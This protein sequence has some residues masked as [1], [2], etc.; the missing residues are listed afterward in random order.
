MPGRFERDALH[1]SP[2][3]GVPRRGEESVFNSPIVA[4]SAGLVAGYMSPHANSKSRG[5]IVQEINRFCREEDRRLGFQSH[6]Q[7]LRHQAGIRPASPDQELRWRRYT[8]LAETLGPQLRPYAY[9]FRTGLSFEEA[10]A[11]M[12]TR[13][14]SA[15][16]VDHVNQSLA[17]AYPQA[18]G[19]A[20]PELRP[21]DALIIKEDDFND[22]LFNSNDR[23]ANVRVPSFFTLTNYPNKQTII[24]E[25]H[26]RETHNSPIELAFMLLHENLHRATQT[27]TVPVSPDD[28]FCRLVFRQN[29]DDYSELDMYHG[30]GRD[31]YVTVNGAIINISAHNE[32]GR[33]IAAEYTGYDLNEAITEKLSHKPRMVLARSLRNRFY[34]ES[35]ADEYEE[36][37]EGSVGSGSSYREVDYIPQLD[38]LFGQLGLT[39]EADILQ[40]YLM[41]DIPYLWLNSQLPQDEYP[42]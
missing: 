29:M 9:A 11:D 34:T 31:I 40:A 32:E 24:S 39:S 16:V 41:G 10:F 6:L 13:P 42:K 37:V 20:I 27:T 22:M 36:R 23:S 19:T 12:A 14:V 7:T 18:F 21:T 5:T 28:P 33:P 4:E 2:L 15:E 38:T 3:V 8:H 25:R 1:Q 30:Q 26:L 35:D 17:T